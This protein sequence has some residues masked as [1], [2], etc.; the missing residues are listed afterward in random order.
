MSNADLPRPRLFLVGW[1]LLFPFRLGH[2]MRRWSSR[3]H[4]RRSRVEPRPV[5]SAFLSFPFFPG[6]YPV[7]TVLLYRSGPPLLLRSALPRISSDKRTR[8][9]E[10]RTS[11]LC[12]E[13]R[14][15]EEMETI[16]REKRERRVRRKKLLHDPQRNE[17]F[18]DPTKT[19]CTETKDDDDD[20]YLRTCTRMRSVSKGVM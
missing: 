17:G 12:T 18:S 10:K 11:V 9:D 3:E 1:S 6:R 14:E 15:R 16:A 20:D 7:L 2:G 4:R 19:D 5:G 8:K 13:T